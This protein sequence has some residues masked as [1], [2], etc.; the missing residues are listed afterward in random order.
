MHPLG[1]PPPELRTRSGGASA[2]RDVAVS[3]EPA[4]AAEPAST[5]DAAADT[6]GEH[7]SAGGVA[8][9]EASP[10][11]EA[12]GTA[13]DGGEARRKSAAPGPVASANTAAD[14]NEAADNAAAEPPQRTMMSQ[15][16][17]ARSGLSKQGV[18]IVIQHSPQVCG[19][20]PAARDECPLSTC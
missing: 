2:E 9:R 20:P 19:R 10:G 3:R 13:L 12:L 1:A 5:L 4:A 15:S 6:D 11:A 17:F 14:K 16:S 7:D 8:A 18:Q